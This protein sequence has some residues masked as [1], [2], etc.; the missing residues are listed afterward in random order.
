MLLIPFFSLLLKFVVI[1]VIDQLLKTIQLFP[2]GI[3]TCSEV[4][5]ASIRF[6]ECMHFDPHTHTGNNRT[7][8]ESL[9]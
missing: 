5:Q 4:Q 6:G 7:E 3:L 9:E 1:F 2:L 8:L